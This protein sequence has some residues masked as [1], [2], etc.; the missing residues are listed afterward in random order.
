[1]NKCENLH[2]KLFKNHHSY[3][4][5]KDLN[6]IFTGFCKYKDHYND[7]LEFFCKTHNELYCTACISKIKK[8]GKGQHT[9][10]EICLIEDIKNEKQKQLNENIKK[11]ESLSNNIN[12]LI[13]QLKIIYEKI[14][15]NK[16][17]IK[18]KIQKIFT[19]IRNVINDREEELLLEVDKK[20]GDTYFNENII[21]DSEKL[22]DKIKTSLENGKKMNEKWNEENKLNLLIHDCIN[23]ENNI[24]EINLI[25]ENIKKTKN[26]NEIKFKF[27]PEEENEIQ[28]FVET[29]KRFENIIGKAQKL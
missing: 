27:L 12:E 5:D 19:K 26:L 15:K 10:C 22:P 11:L 24:N 16:E 29:M 8:E 17:E 28:N 7:V 23:I 14:N 4:S 18:L 6:D 25:N 9:D 20:Y 2:S 13:K 1:M 3:K 21:K